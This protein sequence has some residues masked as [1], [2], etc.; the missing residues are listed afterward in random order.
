MSHG[1]GG[2]DR[3][4]ADPGDA[5]L[6]ASDLRLALGQLVRRLRVEHQLSLSHASVLARL[7]REGTRHISS[8]A[9]AERVRPQSMAQTVAELEAED[10][11]ERRADPTDGRRFLIDMTPKGRKALEADR[12]RRQGWLTQTIIEEFSLDERARLMDAV[13][14]LRQLGEFE[15]AASA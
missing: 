5:A 14:L 15:P 13:A 4:M 7:D 10:L 6:L 3:G 1:C 9:A 2:Y 8:L 11:V 12:Q